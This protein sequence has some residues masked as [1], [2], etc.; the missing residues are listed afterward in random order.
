MSTPLRDDEIPPSAI[1]MNAKDYTAFWVSQQTTERM[2]ALNETRAANGGFAALCD[3][4]GRA[5]VYDPG[6][7]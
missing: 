1:R 6:L 2:R 3:E 5:V 7:D 4:H